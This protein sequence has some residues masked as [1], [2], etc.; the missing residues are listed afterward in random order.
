MHDCVGVIIGGV[1]HTDGPLQVKYWGVLTPVT[2]A[3]LTPMTVKL[4]A[5]CSI[6]IELLNMMTRKQ[7]C[8]QFNS[9][10]LVASSRCNYLQKKSGTDTKATFTLRTSVWRLQSRHQSDAAKSTLDV[11]VVL[12]SRQGLSRYGKHR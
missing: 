9:Y 5:K 1:Q 8:L 11:R 3:A 6:W 7:F 12:Y 2:P 4:I 10:N